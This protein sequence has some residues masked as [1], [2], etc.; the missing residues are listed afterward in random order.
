MLRLDVTPAADLDACL[1]A[2]D[3]DP[4]GHAFGFYGGKDVGFHVLTLKDASLVDS[5]IHTDNS[6]DW[7]SLA[8]TITHR[9]LLDQVAEVPASGIEDKS[10]IRYHRDPHLPVTNIDAGK[11]NF[12]FF[13]SPTRMAQIRAVAAHGEKMP[14]KSTDFYP[15]MLSGIALLPI[16]DGECL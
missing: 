11:G 9:V 3:A 15:K 16:G 2:V 1:A 4:D 10:M 6:H 14:Q 8:V 5:L 7:K 12:V 13:L